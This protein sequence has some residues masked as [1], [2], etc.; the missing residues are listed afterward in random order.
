MVK[1]ED[2][3]IK[4]GRYSEF[5]NEVTSM[6]IHVMAVHMEGKMCSQ[7]MLTGVLANEHVVPPVLCVCGVH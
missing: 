7:E 1:F 4:A 3:E 5:R 6:S 2:H